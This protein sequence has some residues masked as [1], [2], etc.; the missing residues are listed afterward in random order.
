MFNLKNMGKKANI[1]AKFSRKLRINEL[2]QFETIWLVIFVGDF[3]NG[4]ISYLRILKSI[5]N[6]YSRF[7]VIVFF[8]FLIGV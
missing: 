7:K 8:L 1:N 5:V 3:I 6:F 2:V 4:S